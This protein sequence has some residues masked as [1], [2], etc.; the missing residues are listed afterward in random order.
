MLDWRSEP[1]GCFD[2]S[3]VIPAYNEADRIS[4]YLS[5]ITDYFEQQLR[6]YEVLV[7]DDGSTD[8]TAAVVKRHVQLNPCIRLLRLPKRCGK[9]AAIRHGM[10]AAKGCLRLFADA[11]GATPISELA[12][13]EKSLAEGAD[14]SI[15]SRALAARSPGFSV[16]KRTTRRVLGRLFNT[17]VQRSGIRGI[18]DTQCGFKLFR[19]DVAQDLFSHSSINGF[20]FDL[21]LLYV[22]GR[23]GYRIAEVPVN[24]HD[25]PGSKFHLLK[26]GIALLRE[27]AAIRLNN[28][29][30][31]YETDHGT[32][33]R[34]GTLHVQT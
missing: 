30:G 22:A 24:W 23:R 1:Y 16:H 7:V 34:G 10:Q 11:D 2:L 17:A 18:S 8:E 12:G 13:L 9:G 5:Q 27:L 25:R 31:F 21:E 14:I 28:R 6:F 3:I 4:P 29:K 15:G 32:G 20:G 33:S 19:K 26:D